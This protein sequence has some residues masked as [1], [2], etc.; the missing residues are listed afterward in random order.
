MTLSR[1]ISIVAAVIFVIMFI[2]VPSYVAK[3][4]TLGLAVA[5]V[6]WAITGWTTSVYARGGTRDGRLQFDEGGAR[7]DVGSG[8]ALL[9]IAG[10]L[11]ASFLAMY[12]LSLIPEV[13]RWIS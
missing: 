7:L 8:L 3:S 9:V 6:I 2:T 13:S 1:I 12:L 10:C 5:A 4:F 11:G